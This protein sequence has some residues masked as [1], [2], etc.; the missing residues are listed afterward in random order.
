MGLSRAERRE[1]SRRLWRDGRTTL[2][3]VGEPLIDGGDPL[4]HKTVPS[5][6]M[7][8]LVPARLKGA[9]PDRQAAW[10]AE[11][12]AFLARVSQ[13][14]TITPMPRPWP[15]GSGVYFA[16][17]HARISIA[18]ADHIAARIAR[19]QPGCPYPIDLLAV[20]A[21]DRGDEAR[22]L[23]EFSAHKHPR[24]AIDMRR[25]D[26]GQWFV[27]HGDILAHIVTLRPDLMR[28]EK[29]SQ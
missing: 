17:V 22:L 26:R 19:L 7:A 16:R 18:W 21:G 11:R 10:E 25:S 12:K 24:A 3:S 8:D 15:K 9:S 28:K 13:H 23:V 20:Q 2:E 27:A 6:D 29:K 14:V 4:R 5:R 1:I